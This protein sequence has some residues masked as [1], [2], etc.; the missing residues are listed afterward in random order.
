[1]GLFGLSVPPAPAS[2]P[3]TSA[4]SHESAHTTSP[5]TNLAS[6]F[7]IFRPSLAILARTAT[8]HA[9]GIAKLRRNWIYRD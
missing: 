5:S 8:L 9:Q 4:S 6:T 3:R 1:V 7:V 2:A